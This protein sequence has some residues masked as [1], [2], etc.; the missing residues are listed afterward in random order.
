MSNN[1]YL[2]KS[3]LIIA[4]LRL[5]GWCMDDAPITRGLYTV[6]LSKEPSLHFSYKIKIT[7]NQSRLKLAIAITPLPTP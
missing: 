1:P 4:S 6:F 3:N 7:P 2:L 5:R